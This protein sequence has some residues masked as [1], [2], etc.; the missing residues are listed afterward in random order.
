MFTS[1]CFIDAENVAHWLKTKGQM[2][3]RRAFGNWNQP[4]LQNFQMGLSAQGFEPCGQAHCGGGTALCPQCQDRSQGGLHFNAVDFTLLCWLWE[5]L[6][7]QELVIEPNTM[8]QLLYG[9]YPDPDFEHLFRD[10]RLAAQ[11]LL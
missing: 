4:K 11:G 7:K 6:E 10:S 1:A 5:T 3:V 9:T 8:R 2:L